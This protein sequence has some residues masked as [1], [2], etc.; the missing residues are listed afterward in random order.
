MA[1]GEFI[2]WFLQHVLPA[3]F[4]CIRHC[5]L[6]APA[7]KAHRLTQARQALAMQRIP[8]ASMCKPGR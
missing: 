3:G 4:K 1:M 7:D 5:G 2:A 8:M 6:L